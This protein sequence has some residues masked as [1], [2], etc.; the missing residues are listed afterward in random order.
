MSNQDN[1]SKQ[2]LNIWIDKEL[3]AQVD[4]IAARDGSSRASVVS[5]ALRAYL[6]EPDRFG[7]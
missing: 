7:A 3:V 2:K 1:K 6:G 4:G 5:A